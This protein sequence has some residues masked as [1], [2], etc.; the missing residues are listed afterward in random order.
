MKVCDELVALGTALY[1]IISCVQLVSSLWWMSSYSLGAMHPGHASLQASQCLC[2]TTSSY[3]GCPATHQ[4]LVF[5]LL[6]L[7]TAPDQTLY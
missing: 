3:Q 7:R 1:S 4:T 6:Q 5:R 2:T